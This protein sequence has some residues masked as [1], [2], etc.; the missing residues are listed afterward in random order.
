MPREK[1]LTPEQIERARKLVEDGYAV[2]DIAERF[3]VSRY[4]LHSY[5]IRA[6]EKSK[7]GMHARLPRA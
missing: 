2:K 1:A 5:G 6:S 7:R 4:Q 3:G